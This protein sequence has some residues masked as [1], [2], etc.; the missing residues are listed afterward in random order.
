MFS[1]NLKADDLKCRLHTGNTHIYHVFRLLFCFSAAI[2]SAFLD[3]LTVTAVL[4]GVTIGFYR[5]YHAV[6]SG[7]N[8]GEEHNHNNDNNLTE[9]YHSNY[10]LNKTKLI[11]ESSKQIS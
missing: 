1:N 9:A 11:T 10:P 2:L 4:I 5:I 8:F 7:K 6:A 3:A